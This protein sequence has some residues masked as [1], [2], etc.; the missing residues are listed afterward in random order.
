M[1]RQLMQWTTA[2]AVVC[3]VGVA[4]A[5]L[6]SKWTFN[7]GTVNGTTVFNDEKTDDTAGF[8]GA[9]LNPTLTYVDPTSIGAITGGKADLSANHNTAGD[10]GSDAPGRGTT[11]PGVYLDLQNFA[12]SDM[13]YN[14]GNPTRA[15]SIE[16]WVTVSQNRNWA[17]LWDIGTSGG[18]ENVSNGGVGKNYMIGVAQSGRSVGGVNNVFGASV[19]SNAPGDPELWAPVDADPQLGPLS[20]GVEHHVVFT[21]DQNDTTAGANG[22]TKLYL[23]G[24]L[25]GTGVVPTSFDVTG[26]SQTGLVGELIDN[27][28]WFGRAQFNDPLFDG[29]YNEIRLYNNALTP[30][31]VT[32]NFIEGAE[33]LAVPVLNIDRITGAVSLQNPGNNVSP[34]TV[35]NYSITSDIGSLNPAGFTAIDPPAATTTIN[36]I[37]ENGINSGGTIAVGNSLAL[38]T[39]I[40]PSKYED[41]EAFVLLS[42]GTSTAIEVNYIGN[43]GQPLSPLDLNTDGTV[44]AEDFYVF[45]SYSYTDMASLSAVQQALRGDL[46]NDGDNDFIDFD[47]FKRQYNALAGAGALEAIMAG[48]QVPEPSSLAIGGLLALGALCYRRRAVLNGGVKKIAGVLSLAMVCLLASS[49]RADLVIDWDA[50]DWAGTKVGGWG[51]GTGSDDALWIDKVS[52]VIAYPGGDGDGNGG[53]QKNVATIGGNTLADIISFQVDSFDVIVGGAGNASTPLGGLRQYTIAAVVRIPDYDPPNIPENNFWQHNGIVG[54]EAGGA[55]VGD[56]NLG[57][58]DLADN[59][60]GVLV[61]GSALGAGDI[62]TVPTTPTAI[63]DGVWHTVHVKTVDNGDDT[64][65]QFLYIDGA[66]VGA[67]ENIAY[68]GDPTNLVDRTFAIGARFNGDNGYMPRMDLARLQFHNAPLDNAAIAAEAANF[69]TESVQTSVPL[70]LV[71]GPAGAV[72]IENNNVDTDFTIDAYEIVADTNAFNRTNWNSLDDQ[73]I[74]TGGAPDGDFN[75]DGTTNL[76][77]YTVWRDNLGSTGG[78]PNNGGLDGN[79]DADYYQLWKANFGETGGGSGLGWTELSSADPTNPRSALR[80]AFLDESGSTLAAGEEWT[81]GNPFLGGTT[82]VTFR[83]R[84]SD[85]AWID[86]TVAF[87][88]ALETAQVPEPATVSLLLITAGVVAGVRY[89]S[90]L[91]K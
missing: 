47:L 6:V 14:G 26:G 88:G 41:V 22:T 18:G 24:N 61:A 36:E 79:V 60:V 45:A 32:A 40:T 44:D 21:L 83:F 63:D 50:S 1:R 66:Q 74:D 55:G 48:A 7:S 67:D 9:S 10:W 19:R 34:L 33:P 2:A 43:G 46:D 51:G 52:G 20:T 37:A 56:W 31:Q 86:G 5:E 75:N 17:R 65:S 11:A 84:R 16:M 57:V 15:I 87:A 73:D 80:E 85:G 59:G 25:A 62:G 28:A 35:V 29:L 42:D 49:A 68:G 23:N 13:A 76:A 90:R 71:I 54:V 58:T 30:A 8:G 4:Q 64:W 3:S 77:D 81:L 27:N 78:L 70:N 91:R 82:N 69:L 12:I 89:R 38:G 39:A 72:R 53:P